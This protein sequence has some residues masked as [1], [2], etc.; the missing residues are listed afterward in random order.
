MQNLYQLTLMNNSDPQRLSLA[1]SYKKMF[2]EKHHGGDCCAVLYIILW[3]FCDNMCQRLSG[4]SDFKKISDSL[5]QI[6]IK[7]SVKNYAVLHIVII[8]KRVTEYQSLML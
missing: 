5:A 4:A 6:H 7:N 2:H 3:Q 1:D 8:L